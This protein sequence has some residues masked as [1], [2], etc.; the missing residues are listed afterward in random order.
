MKEFDYSLNYKTLDFSNS[1]TKN[2]IELDAESRECSL[3][4]HIPKISVSIGG[5]RMRLLLGSLLLK[6][7]KCSWI[8]HGS[9]TSLVWTWQENS[10]RWDLLAPEGMQITVVE[11]NTLKM[12]RYYPRTKMH[13]LAQKQKQQESLNNIGI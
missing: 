2:Y 6:Y 1:D 3:C 5:S 7:T 12:V 4:V 8:I 9:V 13:L 10:L 11:K